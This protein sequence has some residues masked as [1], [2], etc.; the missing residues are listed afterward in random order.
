MNL[1]TLRFYSENCKSEAQVVGTKESIFHLANLFE[2]SKRKFTVSDS[3]GI[4]AQEVL[5]YGGF[6]YWVMKIN[7]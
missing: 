1:Y 6:K 7:D 5:G 2:I 3:C 4:L